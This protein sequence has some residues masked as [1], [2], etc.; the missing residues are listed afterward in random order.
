MQSLKKE[1]QR[2]LNEAE[3]FKMCL[4]CWQILLPKEKWYDASGQNVKKDPGCSWVKI[5]A[6]IDASY[7]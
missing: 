5:E 1:L 3:R 7:L 6:Q 2:T 4:D